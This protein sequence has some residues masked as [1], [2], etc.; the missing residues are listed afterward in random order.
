MLS[1]IILLIVGGIITLLLSA[2]YSRLTRK[3]PSL[4]WRILPSVALR[5]QNMTAFNIVVINEGND[6]AH[7]VRVAVELPEDVNADTLEVQPSESSLR[8]SVRNLASQVHAIEIEMPI[9][10]SG[11]EC[12][13]SFVTHK[14][15]EEKP[16]VSVT[17]D[18]NI[19]G[20]E[21]EG[22]TDS[23]N[24]MLR[25]RMRLSSAFFLTIFIGYFSILIII[26]LRTTLEQNDLARRISVGDVYYAIGRYEDA[27]KSYG[28]VK[29][30]WPSRESPKA[31]YFEARAWGAAS[32][33]QES[34]RV[35]LQISNSERQLLKRAIEHDAGF[36]PIRNDPDFK[37]FIA[38]MK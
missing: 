23:T 15:R 11:V 17:A 33:A 16:G 35:L 13:L 38:E 18:G 4:V 8:Y 6:A 31:Q 34:I 32:N 29:G 22:L 7:N 28:E 19:I 27:A 36:I 37:A 30:W 14:S 5:G 9:L 1:Q 10:H 3:T 25:K 20:K 2:L 21:A 24:R 12:L 26:S